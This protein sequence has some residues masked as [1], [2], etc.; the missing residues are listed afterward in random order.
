MTPGNSTT[1]TRPPNHKASTK[2]AFGQGSS[3]NVAAKKQRQ[4]WSNSNDRQKSREKSPQKPSPEKA[5]IKFDMTEEE[6]EA[7]LGEMDDFD[8]KLVMRLPN[9]QS[10]S[11]DDSDEEYWR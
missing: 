9:T 10:D 3:K 5:P 1:A 4:Q 11:D 6:K 7:Q 8:K 2:V